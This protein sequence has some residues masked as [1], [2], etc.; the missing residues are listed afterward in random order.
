MQNEAVSIK[1]AKA[2]IS[3]LT[4]QGHS[5]YIVG[6][7]VR[8]HI[9]GKSPDDIDI[10]T[11]AHPSEIRQI[12]R[13][14]GWKTI[15]VGAAFGVIVVLVQGTPYEVA[16]YRSEVYGDDSHRPVSVT[17]CPALYDDLARRDFTM[18]ALAMDASGGIID[19]FGGLADIRQQIIRTVGEPERRFA[20]DGLRMLRAARFA[21][22]LGF[23]VEKATC[24]AM[25][26]T[27][28]RVAGLSVE[29]VRTEIEKILLADYPEQG[30]DILLQSGLMVQSC[31]SREHGRDAVVPVL[32]ELVHLAGLPQNPLFHYYDGW[33]HT[34]AAVKNTPKDLTL[35][36]A[37]LLHDVAKGWEGVRIINKKGA[38]S[39]PGHDVKGAQLAAD[40]TKRLKL[41][42]E[43]GK[44]IVWL[45][46]NHMRIP[47]AEYQAALKW[48]RRLSRDFSRP[49]D[50]EEA[51]GQLLT[52]HYADRIGG[53][54]EPDIEHWEAVFS[55]TRQI[56]RQI[57]FFPPQLA[58]SGQEIAAK[59]GAGRQVGLCQ[60]DF[61]TRIQAGALQ[62]TKNS[63]LAALDAKARRSKMKNNVL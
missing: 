23:N 50:M 42:C 51:V 47:A 58:V 62:N 21:A 41:P 59:L 17:F 2:I 32:P 6:G 19:H 54:V 60:Q 31:R 3:A 4:E 9:L 30:L 7:A 38:Y 63:L 10:A 34:L 20:E 53:H 16:T 5:A 39:D 46:R 13:S 15:E 36:W 27:L 25:E 56:W 24:Q 33:G 49:K 12:A 57:P 61:I 44:R 8:D 52:L 43:Q 29:R 28:S 1:Q 11:D 22:Q 48:L 40:I 18:N 26:K 55:L 45:I 14:S 35:R 37:A